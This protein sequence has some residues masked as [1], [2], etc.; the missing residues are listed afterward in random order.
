MDH[1]YPGYNSVQGSPMSRD[2]QCPRITNVQGSPMCN[3]WGSPMSR[4]H[5]CVRITNV[6]SSPMLL[7]TCSSI[8]NGSTCWILQ[9]L[10]QTLLE[11]DPVRRISAFELMN[12]SWVAVSRHSS[13]IVSVQCPPIQLLTNH[14]V[15][16]TSVVYHCFC[17][18]VPDPAAHHVLTRLCC[19]SLFLS[20]DPVAHHVNL[21]SVVQHCFCLI[22]L[23]PTAHHVN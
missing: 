14:H 21:T 19:L 12:N 8:V 18:H 3:V 15:N 13:T 9:D 10:L 2:H 7:E 17:S 4:D 16:S 6:G 11:L 20:P 1:Q 23:D 22:S 5:Q